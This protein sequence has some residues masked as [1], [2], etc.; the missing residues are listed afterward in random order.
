VHVWKEVILK[1]T[2]TMQ[3]AIEVLNTKS[4]R[5]VMVVDDE[6]RMVGTVTDGDIRR[7]LLEHLPLDAT[8]SDFMFKEPTVADGKE[9]RG[10]IIAMMRK[11]GLLQ[12]PILD[13]E[14]RIVG[15]EMLQ[16][17]LKTEKYDNPVFLMAGGFGKRLRPLTDCTPKPLLKVGNKPILETILDQFISAGFHDFY[18]STH[19]K[20]DMVREHFRDGS[21]WD[22]SIKY[23]HEEEPLGTAGALGLLPKDLIRLP[24]L[25]MNCDLLTNV[26]FKQLLKFHLDQDGD[27]TMCVREYDYHVPYG[28][29]KAKNH[30]ITS[31]EE[32]PI[33]KFFVNAGIYVLDSSVLGK[34]D[35]T[36]YLD[37]PHILESIIEQ[38]GQVNMF[39]IHE[40]WLDVGAHDDYET[41]NI[42]FSDNF[43]KI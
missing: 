8:I 16:D 28:V 3:S 26:D 31:I 9:S 4:P 14:K 38:G 43:C 21:D 29:I 23:V 12:I 18:I 37:M 32:K 35:G 30:R 25:V 19:Y 33:H 13:E 34:V 15:L 39:P 6:E 40:Y 1:Q 42:E 11:L 20:A 27:A 17:L 7:G 24:I 2:D 5:I 22:V 36:T 41:A 10:A